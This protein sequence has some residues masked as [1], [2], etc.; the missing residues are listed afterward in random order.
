MSLAYIRQLDF[1]DR[2]VL[3]IENELQLNEISN[4]FQ[5]EIP[6][7]NFHFIESKDI[8]LIDPRKW[9]LSK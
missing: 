3:G 8:Q 9:N 1:V 7:S 6:Q 2:I 4:A 5:V